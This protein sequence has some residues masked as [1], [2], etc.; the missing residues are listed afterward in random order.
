M[1][2]IA[3]RFV[4]RPNRFVVRAALRGGRQVEA[5]LSDPGRLR[6]LLREGARLRLQPAPAGSRRRT[7][8][9]V[10]LVHSGERAGTWVSVNPLRANRL[11]EP[12]L[13]AGRVRGV[14]RG[15]PLR[16]EVTRGSSRFDFLL[17]GPGGTPLWVEIKSV[18]LVEDG[19]ARFPDAPTARG[20]R[21][22]DELAAL[23]RN[24]D[25]A[26]VLFIVQRADARCVAPHAEIDPAFT[27]ALGAARLAGVLLRAARF[28]LD[29]RGDARYAGALPVRSPSERRRGSSCRVPG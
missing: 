8:Y 26:M 4:S 12:L 23:T 9:S 24:G 6:E 29:A 27:R 15:W 10:E 3:A 17:V 21:H 19:V 20:R 11:A 25:R 7:R 2:L 28:E 13:S 1:N 22:V 5:H 14:G 18:T 16:R